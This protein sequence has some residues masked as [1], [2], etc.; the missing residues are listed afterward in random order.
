MGLAICALSG[1][2]LDLAG[3]NTLLQGRFP[4]RMRSSA[5]YPVVPFLYCPVASAESIHIDAGTAN[6]RYRFDLLQDFADQGRC[7]LTCRAHVP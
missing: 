3:R 4:V 2:L 1:L 5:R 7:M 6:Q